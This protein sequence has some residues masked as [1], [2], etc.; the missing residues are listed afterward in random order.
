MDYSLLLGLHDCAQAQDDD[1]DDDDVSEDIEEE[2]GSGDDGLGA[3]A[4]AGAVTGAGKAITL[5]AEQTTAE[6]AGAISGEICEATAC[7]VYAIKTKP[8]VECAM[9]SI[10]I[11]CMITIITLLTL[12]LI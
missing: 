11:D 3:E 9:Q 10:S 7:F 6:V 8:E 12:F 2:G 1:Y 4:S 5:P